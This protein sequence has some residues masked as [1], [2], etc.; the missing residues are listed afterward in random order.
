[1]K[2]KTKPIT[3][4][5]SVFNLMLDG[6]KRTLKQISYAT[7]YGEASVN[8]SLQYM[9]AQGHIVGKKYNKKE[10]VY[11]YWLNIPLNIEAKP[12][13]WDSKINSISTTKIA[14]ENPLSFF[15]GIGCGLFFSALAIL[16]IFA[17]GLL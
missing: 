5:S 8:A 9:P 16:L 13:I 2:N 15:Y 17:V 10:N 6:K 12:I 7:G 3:I 11:Y 4:D 14:D 1:M